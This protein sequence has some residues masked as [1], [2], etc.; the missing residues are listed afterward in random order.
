LLFSLDFENFC[1]IKYSKTPKFVFEQREG[2]KIEIALDWRG[3]VVF[4][5]GKVGLYSSW[6][7]IFSKWG[8]VLFKSGV[9]FKRIRY[10]KKPTVIYVS[11]RLWILTFLSQKNL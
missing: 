1:P 9:A 11:H 6:G 2:K 3:R 8:E 10:F 5:L 4:R 7:S